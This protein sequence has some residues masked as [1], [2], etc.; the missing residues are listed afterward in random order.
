VGINHRRSFPFPLF[1]RDGQPMNG[2]QLRVN[3]NLD[4]ELETTTA[5]QQFDIFITAEDSISAQ[6]PSGPRLMHATVAR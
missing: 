1:G 5:S 4:G 6:T 3:K 2:G